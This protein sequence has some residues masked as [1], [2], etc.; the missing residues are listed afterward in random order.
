MKDL[1]KKYL[2]WL[3]NSSPKYMKSGIYLTGQMPV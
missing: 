3:K 2:T 1:I